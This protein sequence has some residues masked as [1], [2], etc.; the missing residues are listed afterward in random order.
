MGHPLDSGRD[1][2]FVGAVMAGATIFPEW[3]RTFM[4]TARYV[5]PFREDA[6]NPG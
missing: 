1:A 5:G 6:R 3:A 4:G 2:P